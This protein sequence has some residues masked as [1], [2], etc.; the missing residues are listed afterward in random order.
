MRTPEVKLDRPQSQSKKLTI[1]E[2]R[3]IIKKAEELRP[4]IKSWRKIA[5]IIGSEHLK[6]SITHTTVQSLLSKKSKVEDQTGELQNKRF[7][8]QSKELI[9]WEQKL[10]ELIESAFSYGT[11]SLRFVCQI[12]MTLTR[13]N[14]HPEGKTYFG[15]KWCRSYM[16]RRSYT[17]RRL[18][19]QKRKSVVESGILE[20]SS[21]QLTEL[22]S[23]YND[24]CCIN[25]VLLLSLMYTLQPTVR[26]GCFC[27]YPSKLPDL[28]EPIH[29]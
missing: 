18:Q 21:K 16:K 14:P 26:F 20:K 11:I 15:R 27:F 10:E 29:N 2:K 8:T 5:S 4:S 9:E 6:R 19:G 25:F 24:D 17:Y 23:E 28:V 13:T 1:A 7:R 12:I 22:L 3:L